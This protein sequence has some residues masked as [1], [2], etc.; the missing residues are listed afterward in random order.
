MVTLADALLPLFVEARVVSLGWMLYH[1]GFD[2]FVGNI[3]L[4]S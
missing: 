3:D 2:F 4:F 1:H